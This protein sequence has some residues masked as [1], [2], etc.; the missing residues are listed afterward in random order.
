MLKK[1][2][3]IANA[4]KPRWE[5]TQQVLLQMPAEHYFNRQNN[6]AIHN[7]CKSTKEIP[8]GALSLLGLGLNFCI[9]HRYPTNKIKKS[10]DRFKNDIRTKQLFVGL[11]RQDDFIP[12]LYIKDP[13]WVAPPAKP[14]VEHCLQRFATRLQTEQKNTTDSAALTSHAY[15]TT[16]YATSPTTQNA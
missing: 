10:I 3:F 13:H 2:G 16:H 7:L 11:E 4:S 15:K 14:K 9:K 1:F 6:T 12:Q 8:P 5:N